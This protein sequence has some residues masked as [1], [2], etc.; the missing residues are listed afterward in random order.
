MKKSTMK[1][2]ACILALCTVFGFA[3]CTPS[4]TVDGGNGFIEGVQRYFAPVVKVSKSG[5]ATWSDLE[6]AEKYAYRINGGEEVETTE[7]SVQLGLYD[8]IVVKCI[9][10]GSTRNDSRWSDSAQ[11]IP[12]H[13]YAIEGGG[14]KSTIVNV[15]KPDGTVVLDTIGGSKPYGDVIVAGEEYVVEFDITVGPYHNALL[16]AGVENAVISDLVWSDSSYA[17]R[18]GEQADSTD[19]L[20]EVLYE[21]KYS[22]YPDYATIHRS[23]WASGYFA[24]DNG[25]TLE[26]YGWKMKSKPAANNDGTYNTAADGFW[27]VEPNWCSSLF[28]AHFLSTKKH[29]KTQMEAGYKYVRFKIKY[30]EIRNLSAGVVSGGEQYDTANG[31]IGFNLFAII[32]QTEQCIFFNSDNAPEQTE[33]DYS[34][35][36]DDN[37]EVATDVTVYDAAT[38]AAVLIG[39]NNGSVLETGKKYVLEFDVTGSQNG[40][41]CL[42]GIE[43]ALISDVTWS[44]KTYANR[45]GESA[46][47]DSLC[48]LEL[49]TACHHLAKDAP[50]FH[51]LWKT[52]GGYTGNY[53][54]SACMVNSDG[55]IDTAIS[56][57]R[58]AN[59]NRCL[60][61]ALK[62]WLASCK[63]S[64]E[65]GKQYFRM[66]IEWRTFDVI[67]VGHAV[68][69]K[70]SPK[71]GELAGSFFNTFVYSPAGGRYLYLTAYTP[72]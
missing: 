49:D 65:T 20:Y 53:R 21:T 31:K 33:R 11:Y 24:D 22:I 47:A 43:D 44:N 34:Y 25:K 71:Y 37:G 59:F 15:Y 70:N 16:L 67:E 29:T 23:A 39:G 28:G 72:S 2:L 35:V 69:D 5:L 9:G 18:A 48:V 41:V 7:K 10:N 55:E 64:N 54:S 68:E 19:K 27:T 17:S 6:G 61:F 50:L 56:S 4:G 3:A 8:K 1:I 26:T 32:H 12:A 62:N 66:T 42:T 58:C 52:S 57:N 60:E 46:V 13:S 38:G 51:R 63:S 36:T 30:N 14:G 45:S 40:R